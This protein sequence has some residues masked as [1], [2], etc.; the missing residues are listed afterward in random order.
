MA[1]YL[2]NDKF[3]VFMVSRRASIT[4]LLA[5]V[6]NYHVVPVRHKLAGGRAVQH[7]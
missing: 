5:M 7:V 6:S 4:L 1:V 3:C 2:S